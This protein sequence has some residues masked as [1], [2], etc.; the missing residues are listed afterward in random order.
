MTQS[1]ISFGIRFADR[2]VWPWGQWEQEL[3]QWD[4]GDLGT[5]DSRVGLGLS[6]RLA[7]LGTEVL[8]MRPQTT[9]W[10]ESSNTL[11]F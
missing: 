4:Q 5:L 6:T 3:G 8:Q 7:A 10:K 2:S 1:L 11:S 9:T